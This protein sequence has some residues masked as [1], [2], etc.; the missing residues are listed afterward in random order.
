MKD[1]VV[2]KQPN[3]IT[4]VS[5][6]GPHSA[7]I[8]HAEN[9]ITNVFTNQNSDNFDENGHPLTPLVPTRYDRSKHTI[10]LGNEE[11]IIPVELES[12]E[13]LSRQD[14]PYIYALCD[15]YAEKLSRVITPQ[16][17]DSLPDFY[18]KDLDRQR[19]SFYGAEYEI[20]VK[21]F[22]L[23]RIRD[24]YDCVGKYNEENESNLNEIIGL[25]CPLKYIPAYGDFL[26][27]GFVAK[28]IFAVQVSGLLFVPA[29]PNGLSK[30]LINGAFCFWSSM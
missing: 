25:P 21:P 15:V 28:V 2:Q 23:A 18:K 20:T 29:L 16:S 24:S 7:Y 27:T 4:S 5:Q 3:N 22:D 1:E 17:V 10:Y 13:L 26:I 14:L 11:I 6:Y 8:A 19:Q 12:E 9:A 30:S